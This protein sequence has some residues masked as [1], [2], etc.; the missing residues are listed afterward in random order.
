MVVCKLRMAR[1]LRVGA[2][3]LGAEQKPY[4]VAENG[5]CTCQGVAAAAQR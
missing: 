5:I 4:N 2:Q 3:L 1:N